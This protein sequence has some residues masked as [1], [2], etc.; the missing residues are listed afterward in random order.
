VLTHRA[1][2]REVWGPEYA[3]EMQYLRNVIASL[4]RKLERDPGHPEHIVTEPGTG[5]RFRALRA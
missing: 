2:L 1:I 5:F 3:A 4:R